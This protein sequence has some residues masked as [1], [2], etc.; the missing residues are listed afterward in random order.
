MQETVTELGPVL[1][2]ITGPT[3]DAVAGENQISEAITAV[4]DDGT[5]GGRGLN[6]PPPI[7]LIQS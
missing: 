1:P 6:P 2:P 4:R 7:I 3:P 5:P